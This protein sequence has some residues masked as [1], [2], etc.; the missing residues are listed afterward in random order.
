M[1]CNFNSLEFA[2][3]QTGAAFNAY[4]TYSFVNNSVFYSMIPSYYREFMKRYVQNPL[5]WNDGWVPYFHNQDKGILST[6]LAGAIVD[7]VARKVAG[8]RIMYKNV[9]E[10]KDDKG[11]NVTRNFIADW[12]EK[13][14]F[15]S[16]LKRGIK[17]AAAGGTALLKT[18]KNA[19]GDLWVESLRFDRFMPTVDAA[20]GLVRDVKCY[21]NFV[22]DESKSKDGERTGA[23]CLIEHRYFG[24]Y[25]TVTG[26]VIKNAALVEYEVSRAYGSITNGEFVG[27]S[28]E[29][30]KWVNLPDKIRKAFK[31][32]YGT[33]RLDE[34][35]LMPFKDWLGCELMNWTDGI[36]GMP[37]MPFGESLI[38]KAIPFLQEYDYLT[39]VYG[40]EMYLGRA[41]VMLSQGL[42]SGNNRAGLAGGWDSALNDQAFVRT[43]SVNPEDDKPLPIQFEIRSEALAKMRNNLLEAI[44][45]NVGIS[46]STLAPFLQDSS[47]RTAREVSTEENETA[48]FV[49]DTRSVLETAINATLKHICEYYRALHP[50]LLDTVG[51][52]WSQA[53][54]SNP[55][56]TTEMMTQQ[57]NAGLISLKGAIS[58]LNPDE[59]EA[60]IDKLVEE[61]K[62][63]AMGHADFNDK[64]YYDDNETV[65]PAGDNA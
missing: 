60:Q 46:P 36:T 56:M 27:N 16:A 44:A 47:A 40:T 6:R 9:G 19:D 18:N 57:Y 61:A 12:A 42:D 21:L 50:E 25:T 48:G 45:V 13:V 65:E 38:L 23:Y 39:S 64:D 54:L 10:L 28:C 58:A 14:R 22:I 24:E 1:D 3:W 34:P 4:H 63:D 11:S 29:R 30:I 49:A 51:I 2:P 62:A 26:E 32:N 59:D 8:S 41:R 55:Y 52:R 20:T 31:D 33:V 53:G 35:I 17:Y 7:R 15:E 5:W 43:P 37:G